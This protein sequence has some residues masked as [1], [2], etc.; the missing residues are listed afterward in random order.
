[1]V[2]RRNIGTT[3][4]VRCVIQM[5]NLKATAISIV[6]A[7]VLTVPVS[8]QSSAAV[9]QSKSF[10]SLS[11]R[12]LSVIRSYYSAYLVALSAV[13]PS[14]A[15]SN[16]ISFSSLDD[17]SLSA[18]QAYYLAN[19]SGSF[20][21]IIPPASI[22]VSATNGNNASDGLGVLSAVSTVSNALTKITANITNIYVL[23][24]FYNLGT[25]QIILP[26]GV[27]L[28][29]AGEDAV[30]FF[31]WA[32]CAGPETGSSPTGGPQINQGDNS[33]ASDFTVTCD[34]NS[35]IASVQAGHHS[36]TWA[37]IGVS[38]LNPPAHKGATNMITERVRVL[39]GY[40]DC[41]HNNTTN[42]M[43]WTIRDCE[44]DAEGVLINN[45]CA[46]TVNPSNRIQIVNF[47]G[48]SRG[49]FPQPIL[50]A[51]ANTAPGFL[52]TDGPVTVE[53][54]YCTVTATS[55][56]TLFSGNTSQ[57]NSAP[58]ILLDNCHFWS[59]DTSDT[60]AFN[61]PIVYG[62]WEFKG[63]NYGRPFLGANGR[64]GRAFIQP[65]FKN[66][67]DA[68]AVTLFTLT[69]ANNKFV[70]ARVYATT[71]A[72]DNTDYQAV[73]ETVAVAT[74]NKAGTVASPTV[75]SAV[76]SANKTSSGTL[77]TAWT[78][79][80]SGTT[81]SIKENADSS[82]TGPTIKCLWRVELDTDDTT[83]TIVPQ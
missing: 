61:L 46:T 6:I 22:I 75:A 9:A 15:I 54:S 57:S 20:S 13:A 14:I 37:G 36:G 59:A 25:N 66:L 67:T 49:D 4:L 56:S 7:V 58:R 26:N 63:T 1:L 32:D 2:D 65:I 51:F 47:R 72:T 33:V 24:G 62:T 53:D 16:A 40:F 3:Q 70:G 76:A 12:D 41:F 79:T 55:G 78:A 74:V 35:L 64:A 69:L 28:Y 39:R 48:A 27:N 60:S 34:T 31:G 82:L 42:R 21:G 5:R 44:A 68:T 45:I 71:T 11:D 83:L 81:I 50:D 8:A 19:L 18:I 30:N 77:T 38:Y 52:T 10:Q 29:G 23:P 43:D 73:T 80:V 17:H